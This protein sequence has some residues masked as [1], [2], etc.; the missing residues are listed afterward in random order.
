MLPEHFAEISYQQLSK[1]FQE[2]LLYWILRNSD[3]FKTQKE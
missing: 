1:N 2:I 3:Y